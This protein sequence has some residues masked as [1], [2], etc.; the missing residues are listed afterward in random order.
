M[1]FFHSFDLLKSPICFLYKGRDQISTG[2]GFLLTMVLSILLINSAVHSD[3]FYKLKPS[4]S[5]QSDYKESYARTAF[6]R[7][8]YTLVVKIGD[9]SGVS[10]IDFSYFY[11]NLT[12]NSY[13]ISAETYTMNK[14]FMRICE[15]NDFLEEDRKLNLYGKSFCPSQEE[16]MILRG[17]GTSEAA[18]Y[19]IIEL[20]RCDEY[21]AKHFNVTC[22]T[23]AEM[24]QFMLDK[25]FYY[26]YTDN[27]FD[28]TNLEKPV[29]RSLLLN[30][31]YFYPNIKKT[32]II[33]VQK[34]IIQTDLGFFISNLLFTSTLK[35][36]S[37]SEF[38]GFQPF[39]IYSGVFSDWKHNF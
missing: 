28:L 9:Y 34:T 19:A 21:S 14:Q 6:D 17:S 37:R 18:Q 11:F 7:A 8:N 2:I 15:E 32:N 29:K 35:N 25:I 24:D 27:T 36:F 30:T 20:D 39:P 33:Y 5:V 38:F 23:K 22:K 3:F 1:S 16:P 31:V 13:D 26:Y 4:V 12:F 10:H